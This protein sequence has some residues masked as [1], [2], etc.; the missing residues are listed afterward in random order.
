MNARDQQ[1]GLYDSAALIVSSGQNE[2]EQ[3]KAR[4]L[5]ILPHRQRMN[6]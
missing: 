5:D 6:D 1:D 4:G 3:M 2:I